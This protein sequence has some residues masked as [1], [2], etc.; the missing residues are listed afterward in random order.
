MHID[1]TDVHLDSDDEV[2]RLDL[3]EMVVSDMCED[4]DFQLEETVSTHH[5]D[6]LPLKVSNIREYLWVDVNLNSSDRFI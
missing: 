3:E 1:D 5:A 2:Y 6:F 4:P